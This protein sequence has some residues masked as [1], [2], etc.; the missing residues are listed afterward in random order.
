VKSIKLNYFTSHVVQLGRPRGQRTSLPRRKLEF[1]SVVHII[2]LLITKVTF[3]KRRTQY[4]LLKLFFEK[5][6]RNTLY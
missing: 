2:I 6:E 1:H 3:K 5:N 4:A